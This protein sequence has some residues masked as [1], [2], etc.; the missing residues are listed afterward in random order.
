MAATI[1]LTDGFWP[2]APTFCCIFRFIFR[3]S[4]VGFNPTSSRMSRFLY[5]A[6]GLV[7]STC[8]YIM[9]TAIKQPSI[10]LP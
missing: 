3:A 7:T 1:C 10:V 4:M 5:T 9:L 8:L 6:V 2:V